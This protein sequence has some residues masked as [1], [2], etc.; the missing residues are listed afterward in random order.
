MSDGGEEKKQT[1]LVTCG[2]LALT[3]R[4]STSIAVTPHHAIESIDD[5]DLGSVATTTT[6]TTVPR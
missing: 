2:L 3:V 1:S 6:T 5:I 4:G